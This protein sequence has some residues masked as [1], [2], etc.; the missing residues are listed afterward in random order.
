[1][2]ANP[3]ADADLIQ[4]TTANNLYL[5]QNSKSDAT[6][7]SEYKR[8]VAW[9][10]LQPEL[11]TQVSPFLTRKNVDHYFTRVIGSRNGVTNTIRKLSVPWIGPQKTKST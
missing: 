7:K 6:Y 2:A 1:M 10:V 9:V 11:A 5:S 4:H 3:T 8:F